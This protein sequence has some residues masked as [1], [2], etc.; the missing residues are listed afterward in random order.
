MSTVNLLGK[1]PC[2]R[3]GHDQHGHNLLVGCPHCRCMATPGEAGDETHYAG[4]PRPYTG[5]RILPPSEVLHDWQ[6]LQPVREP[7]EV[8]TEVVTH[9]GVQL[10]NSQGAVVTTR[11]NPGYGSGFHVPYTEAEARADLALSEKNTTKVLVTRTETTVVTT[12]PW[13]EVQ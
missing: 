9:W 2:T 7:D 8:D 4:T 10:L 1:F 5:D 3:C 12:T 11:W 6:R 13:K